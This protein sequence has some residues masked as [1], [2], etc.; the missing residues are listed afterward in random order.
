M[1]AEKILAWLAELAQ[2]RRNF[3]PDAGNPWGDAAALIRQLT[4]ER[5]SLSDDR[6]SWVEACLDART[7]L[8]AA[9]AELAAIYES[10]P[11]G[12]VEPETGNFCWR[13]DALRCPNDA[14]TFTIAVIPRPEPRHD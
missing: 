13:E 2:R 8:A 5:D 10:E 6:D 1:D 4:A 7:D 11:V 14:A 12:Y 3:H 9:R